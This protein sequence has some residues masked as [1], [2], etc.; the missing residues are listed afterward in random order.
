MILSD[1]EDLIGFIIAGHNLYIRYAVSV[2]VSYEKTERI[3]KT[4]NKQEESTSN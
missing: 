2:T 4:G 3:I 1:R